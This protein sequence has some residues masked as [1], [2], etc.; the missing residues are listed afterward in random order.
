[1]KNIIDEMG[2]TRHAMS[3]EQLNELYR[4]IDDF[5]ADCTY[6]EATENRE[7]FAKVKT[8]IHQRMRDTK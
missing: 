7:V 8:M 4:R 5:I 1:M 2:A 3:Y 6:E